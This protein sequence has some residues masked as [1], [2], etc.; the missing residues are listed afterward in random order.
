MCQPRL[1]P[2]DFDRLSARGPFFLTP[3]NTGDFAGDSHTKWMDQVV[4]D[5]A[6]DPMDRVVGVASGDRT[7]RVAHTPRTDN[8]APSYAHSHTRRQGAQQ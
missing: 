4:A 5:F 8:F 2:S 7:D 3:E 6:A 1:Q